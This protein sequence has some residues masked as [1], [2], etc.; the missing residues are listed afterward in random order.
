MRASVHSTLDT[1][2]INCVVI[3]ISYIDS[4]YMSIE[5]SIHYYTGAETDASTCTCSYFVY[6]TTVHV[7]L[8]YLVYLAR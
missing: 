6:I 5:L 7:S 1:G 4:G 8:S 2:A 3:Y